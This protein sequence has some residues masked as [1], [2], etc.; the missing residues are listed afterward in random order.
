MRKKISEEKICLLK[1]YFLQKDEVIMAFIFGSFVDN[2]Q[3]EESDIDIAVYLKAVGEDEEIKERKRDPIVFDIWSDI[4]EIIETEV[5]L[6]VLNYAYPSFIY[7]VFKKGIPLVI[8]N[9]TL[10][11]SLYEIVERE[12]LDFI[13]FMEDY[14][15]IKLRSSSLSEEDKPRVLKRTDFLINYLS[16]KGKFLDI[17]F[18]TFKN[19]IDLKRNIEKWVEDIA[20]CTID[21]SKVILAS[22]K[23]EMPKSYKEC[24]FN[25]GIFFGFSEDEAKKLSELAYLRNILA[26]E[27]LDIL[28]QEIKNFLIT[29]LP[30]IEKIVPLLKDYIKQ[31]NGQ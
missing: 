9:K 21:I 24:L 28:Y 13:P 29:I 23:K 8:K 14:I 26:H 30:V 11:R 18:N 7:D 10:Y 31:Q 2:R 15:D 6:V 19:N 17:D 12:T 20:N 25:I 22:E 1:D 5:D 27:Y 4:E 16:E 3:T